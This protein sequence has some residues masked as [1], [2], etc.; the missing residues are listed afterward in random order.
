M[1]STHLSLHVHIVFSTKNRFPFIA[2]ESRDRLI[3]WQIFSGI[4]NMHLLN[5]FIE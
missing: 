4:S 1:T 5:G 2:N 3:V